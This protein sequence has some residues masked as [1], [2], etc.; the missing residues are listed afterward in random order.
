ML[1]ALE[2]VA[3]R[4]LH[5]A[6]VGKQPTVVPER[7]GNIQ[8]RRDGLRI[9]FCGVGH[10]KNFPSELHTMAFRPW[11]LPPF[12][13][14]EIYSEE[15]ISPDLVT[16]S[17]F[18]GERRTE[19]SDSAAGPRP[20]LKDVYT[21]VRLFEHTCMHAARPNG[22]PAKLPAFAER[23]LNNPVG[24]ELVCCVIVRH[25]SELLRRP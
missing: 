2:L 8:F 19:L 17:S 23:K 14:S 7:I 12:A 10:V 25:C 24:V 13:E 21:A 15:A 20:L 5:H 3:Q 16:G 11:H 22:L 1:L 6:R 9:K 18:A 4:E